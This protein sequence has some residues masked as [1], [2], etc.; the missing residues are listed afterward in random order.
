MRASILIALLGATSCNRSPTLAEVFEEQKPFG[1]TAA[2][3]FASAKKTVDAA[4]TPVVDADCSE[5]L[6]WNDVTPGTVEV[7]DYHHLAAPEDGWEEYMRKL[8]ERCVWASEVEYRI[9][10]P[11]PFV[12]Y[13]RSYKLAA[14]V[15]PKERVNREEKA[16]EQAR[17]KRATRLLVTRADCE[18]GEEKGAIDV[19]L[20]SIPSGSLVCSFRV[21]AGAD[22]DAK[23]TT[24]LAYAQ[25]KTATTSFQNKVRDS[26]IANTLTALNRELEKRFGLPTRR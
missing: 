21:E 3:T 15:W 17:A 20:V 5:K 2:A 9:P 24:T 4:S 11:G 13:A 14:P 7:A 23:N 1:S 18:S 25:G 8:R 26:T 19:F 10:P 16:A 12:G 6:Q 22:G